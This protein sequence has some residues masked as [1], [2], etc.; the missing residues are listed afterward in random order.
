MKLYTIK[1]VHNGK[2]HYLCLEAESND[3]CLET[4]L[5]LEP[6]KY[7]EGEYNQIFLSPNKTELDT[8]CGLFKEGKHIQNYMF[9]KSHRCSVEYY[10]YFDSLEVIEIT[11]K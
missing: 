10:S 6:E 4:D 11:I 5:S 8:L 3:H 1:G 9:D 2:T 7:I